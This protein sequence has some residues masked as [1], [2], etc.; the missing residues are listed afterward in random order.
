MNLMGFGTDY[1]TDYGTEAP[2]IP[3]LLPPS[4]A[5]P[6]RSISKLGI[7]IGPDGIIRRSLHFGNKGIFA[8]DLNVSEKKI[9]DPQ[10]KF[11]Q[12]WNRIFVVSCM[13]A[14]SIDPL[15]FYLPVVNQ[16]SNCLG[17]DSR[18]AVICTTLRTIIDSIYLIRMILQ[19]R[20]AFIAP[21]SRVFGRGELV[22]DPAEIAKRYLRWHF[23][24]DVLSILPIPQILVWKFLHNSKGSNVQQT[25]NALLFIVLIQY[26]PRFFRIL[27]LTSE[28]KRTSGVFAET[29]WAGAAYYL[30]LYILASHIVGSF[31]YLL[32]VERESFCWRNFCL[33]S[34]MCNP[35]FLYC[36]HQLTLPPN[37]KTL[38]TKIYGE[39]CLAKGDDPPFNFGIYTL[40][41]TSGVVASNKFFSKYCYCL[42]WGLQNLST[43]GQGLITSTYPGEVIFSITL[44][45]GGLILFSL[46]IGNMQV[47]SIIRVSIYTS[48]NI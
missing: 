46:L 27:P 10:D 35:T 28:M 5:Q 14:V 24:I 29:A 43:L 22:I 31:W 32:A 1:G 16:N 48:F 41:L 3:G 38:S 20:T 17:I 47:I 7:G 40:A 13:V 12:T 23:I 2:P 34:N 4:Q 25:K 6:G 30:L 26:I 42:W 11:L 44:A 18:L 39:K 33:E 9:F 37:W 8:E 45:I 19:F 36:N 21:S 15:F